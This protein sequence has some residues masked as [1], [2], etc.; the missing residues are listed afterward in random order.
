MNYKSHAF[1]RP[2]PHFEEY[3]EKKSPLKKSWVHC[4]LN[5]FFWKEVIARITKISKKVPKSVNNGPFY[6][7]DTMEYMFLYEMFIFSKVGTTG[8]INMAIST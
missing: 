1:C 2:H 5:A 8:F 4:C 3:T 6:Q 7:I